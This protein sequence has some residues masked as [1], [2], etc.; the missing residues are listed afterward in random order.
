MASVKLW[1]YCS[2]LILKFVIITAKIELFI[3]Q[4]L[5]LRELHLCNHDTLHSHVL[6]NHLVIWPTTQPKMAETDIVYWSKIYM[7]L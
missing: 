2:L 6:H 5:L 3:L 1:S 4:R 7:A